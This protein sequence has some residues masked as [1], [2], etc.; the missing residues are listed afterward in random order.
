MKVIRG[1]LGDHLCDAVARGKRE[2]LLMAPFVKLSVIQR[3][4]A[5]VE[6]GVPGKIYTRWRPEEVAAGVTDL[7][8]FDAVSARPGWCLYLCSD[9][10]AKYYRIDDL[11]II[12]SANLTQSALEWRF[13][14]NIEL[15]VESSNDMPSWFEDRVHAASVLATPDI[16][17]IVREAAAALSARLPP[18]IASLQIQEQGSVRGF[19]TWI[20][21]TRNPSDIFLA[22]R[23]GFDR[24]T[25][26]SSVSVASDLE[27]LEAD[28]SSGDELPAIIRTRLIQHP[29]VISVSEFCRVPRRFGAVSDLVSDWIAR[30]G[31]SRNSDEAWQTLMRWLLFFFP[32]KYRLQRPRHS[33]VFYTVDN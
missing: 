1:E 12:G 32:E 6:E 2:I 25:H 17:Q 16:Q 33:E 14:S 15:L 26:V 5:V 28:F 8:V 31:L 24:L 19:A 21:L 30:H 10:H 9:L 22:Q 11:F 29:L 7:E 13:P 3:L 4:L 27:H 20:P 23:R 18:S